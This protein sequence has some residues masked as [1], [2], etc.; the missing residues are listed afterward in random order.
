VPSRTR[1]RPVESEKSASW[2]HKQVYM[3]RLLLHSISVIGWSVF[4]GIPKALSCAA[5]YPFTGIITSNCI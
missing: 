5:G 1:K 2:P 4:R 3:A